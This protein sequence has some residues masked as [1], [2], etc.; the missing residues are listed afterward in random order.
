MPQI[1]YFYLQ[2]SVPD[3]EE[4]MQPA[5]NENIGTVAENDDISP[6]SVSIRPLLEQPLVMMTLVH[7]RH[8]E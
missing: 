5:L 2:P 1:S 3:N 6:S 7:P 4:P 8:L